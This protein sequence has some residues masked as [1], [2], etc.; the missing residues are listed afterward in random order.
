M[1]NL[2]DTSCSVWLHVASAIERQKRLP[3]V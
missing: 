3:P 2:Y 1:L